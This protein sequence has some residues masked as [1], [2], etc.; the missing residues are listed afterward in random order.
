MITDALQYGI[1]LGWIQKFQAALRTYD[2]PCPIGVDARL[3][4]AQRDGIKSMI[5]TLEG[6]IKEFNERHY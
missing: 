6:E 5:E 4:Q 2:Q 1:T 3:W